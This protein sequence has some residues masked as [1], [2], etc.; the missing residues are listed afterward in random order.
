[1]ASGPLVISTCLLETCCWDVILWLRS[2]CWSNKLQSRI[3]WLEFEEGGCGRR[4]R[5]LYRQN[6]YVFSLKMEQYPSVLTTNIYTEMYICVMWLV[7]RCEHMT[8]SAPSGTR[9]M[10]SGSRKVYWFLAHPLKIIPALTSIIYFSDTGSR[11]HTC[12]R[13]VEIVEQWTEYDLSNY[14]NS[15]TKHRALG[16]ECYWW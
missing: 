15:I 14:A 16:T 7:G 10:S 13:I 4:R 3:R 2:L 11:P 1:M 8:C 6:V 12:C 9:R 5:P